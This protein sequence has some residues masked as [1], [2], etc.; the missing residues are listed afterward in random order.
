MKEIQLTQGK[1]ALVDDED[2]E[3]LN[4][5]K[6]YANR[7][8][9]IFYAHREIN[10]HRDNRKIIHMHRCLIGQEENMFV[11]HIDGNGLN[12]QKSNLRPCTN[13]Q[14]L[15]NRR[16]NKNAS[17][18]YKGVNYYKYQNKKYI[19]FIKTNEKKI[20]IGSFDTEIEAAKAYDEKAK[21]HFG[22]FAWLNFP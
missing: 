8:R 7:C 13:R 3:N 22:E 4:Q 2:F 5:F 18:V 6:W 14:N 20:Y 9:S 19:S 1:V 15:M 16:P 17:S 21:E 10:S 12:N 11:D